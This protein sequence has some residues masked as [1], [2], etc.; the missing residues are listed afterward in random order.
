[1]LIDGILKQEEFINLI[2]NKSFFVVQKR[3]Q[4]KKKK[5]NYEKQ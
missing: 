2:E 4:E 3:K 5:I 1:M